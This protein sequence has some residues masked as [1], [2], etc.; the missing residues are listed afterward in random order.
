MIRHTLAAGILLG[1]PPVLAQAADQTVDKPNPCSD[2]ALSTPGSYR[3]GSGDIVLIQVYGEADL[4]GSFPVDPAG[5]VIIPLVGAVKVGGLTADC[6]SV[7]VTEALADGYLRDPDVTVSLDG[8]RS[9]PV[10]VLGAVKN[11]GLYYLD[12]P[13]TVLQMLSKAGGVSSTGVDALRLTRA[14]NDNDV[15]QIPY[16]PLLAEGRENLTLGAGDVLFVPDLT[17]TV[18][19]SVKNP[20]EV[21]YKEGL[22]I[23]RCLASAGGATDVAN[24]GRVYLQRGDQRIR[25][26]VR[27][28]LAGKDPDLVVKAGDRVFVKESVF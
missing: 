25:V 24:L 3:V 20:G 13:T 12:G 2:A 17:V 11:P 28:V 7:R 15:I 27:R 14:G 21:P 18:L 9:Q 10:S 6:I 23:S 26:N 19:G 22:T 16:E 5:A 4:S 8:Y 1:T